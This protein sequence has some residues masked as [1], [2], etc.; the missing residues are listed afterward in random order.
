MLVGKQ[1]PGLT[2]YSTYVLVV[3]LPIGRFE[4]PIPRNGHF[5]YQLPRCPFPH[6][7]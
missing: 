4:R 3:F 5:E 1:V 7:R 2:L 6:R